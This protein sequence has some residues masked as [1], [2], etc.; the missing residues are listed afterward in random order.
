MVGW[1]PGVIDLGGTE[2]VS[3]GQTYFRVKGPTWN[4]H[5]HMIVSDPRQNANEVVM[6]NMTSIKKGE[7]HDT[8]CVLQVGDH[9]AVTTPSYITYQRLSIASEVDLDSARCAASPV[10]PDR[11]WR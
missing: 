10:S 4:R 7:Y 6:V 5:L 8:A 9:E 2:M 11:A 1:V 3:M